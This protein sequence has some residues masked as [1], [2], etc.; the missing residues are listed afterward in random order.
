V[1]KNVGFWVKSGLTWKWLLGHSRSECPNVRVT[2]VYELM[3]QYSSASM[4]VMTRSVMDRSAASG[5][6]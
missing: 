3:A 6:W 4:M 5:E 2:P 1:Q